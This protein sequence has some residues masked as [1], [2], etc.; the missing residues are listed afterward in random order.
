MKKLFLISVVEPGSGLV[1][2]E[3]FEDID[4]AL[5]FEKH[6]VKDQL[7]A[8]YGDKMADCKDLAIG[9]HIMALH[10]PSK[11]IVINGWLANRNSQW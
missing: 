6:G 7:R 11:D 4:D 9:F 1:L 3:V 2:N 8:E 5:H 10:Q